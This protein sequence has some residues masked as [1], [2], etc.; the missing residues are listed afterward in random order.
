MFGSTWMGSSWFGSPW[1][2]TGDDDDTPP[3]NTGGI[4]TVGGFT[5]VDETEVS[6]HTA[7]EIGG[8]VLV[9]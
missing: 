1:Y 7:V 8:K 3:V 9:I 2:G 5:Y 4:V 6:Q